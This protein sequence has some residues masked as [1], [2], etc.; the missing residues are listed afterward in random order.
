[1]DLSIHPQFLTIAECDALIA[2]GDE[3]G[4]SASSVIGDDG[5]YIVHPART[6]MS[7]SIPTGHNDIVRRIE[8]RCAALA[9][10]ELNQLE[11]FQMVKYNWAQRFDPHYDALDPASAG[12]DIARSGQRLYTVL[13]YLKSPEMGGHTV[14]PHVRRQ[15]NPEQGVALMW[16]NCDEY[17]QRVAESEHGGLPV[18]KGE[19]IALNVWIRNEAY[20]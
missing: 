15:F 7:C 12:D 6:S 9:G 18:L 5:T 14:F 2:I 17:G 11:P 20:R 19:K 13:V 16:K 4:Y 3:M 10:V 1:M 8:A